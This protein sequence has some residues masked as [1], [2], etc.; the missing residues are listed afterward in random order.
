VVQR[1]AGRN[2]VAPVHTALQLV[3]PQVKGAL[4][5]VVE[6]WKEVA[7]SVDPVPNPAKKSESPFCTVTREEKIL[8]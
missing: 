3:V 4:G 5:G 8:R 1:A 2:G 6:A 7:C